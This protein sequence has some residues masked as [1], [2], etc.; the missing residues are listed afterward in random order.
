MPVEI[1]HALAA[2]DGGH[3]I[4]HRLAGAGAGFGEQDAAV[5]E[6]VGD[7]ARHRALAVAR[8]ELIDR[9]R[10]RTVVGER[11][12]DRRAQASRSGYRGNFRHNCST[13]AF[14]SVSDA[15]VVGRG[16]DARDVARR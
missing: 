10:E 1:E 2:Q 6:D 7:V 4:R 3:E 14:T 5:G 15:V 16:E 13:S 9:A 11:L 8:L 12:V